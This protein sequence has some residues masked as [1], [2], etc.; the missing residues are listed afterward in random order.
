MLVIIKT[1]LF[2]YHGYWSSTSLHPPVMTLQQWGITQTRCYVCWQM[3]SRLRAPMVMP[4]GQAWVLYWRWWSERTFWSACFIG[5][6]VEAWT[7]R[8]RG[9]CSSCLRCSSGSPSS[10]CCSTQ[11]SSTP[12][13]G[14]WELV[15]NRSLAVLQHLK[16]V[17]SCCS[18]RYVNL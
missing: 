9:H 1:P 11:L 5:T 10:L 15:V 17:W 6:F 12:Y 4:P 3:S 18:T 8:V 7:Q 13:W 2:R 14:Y 16:T